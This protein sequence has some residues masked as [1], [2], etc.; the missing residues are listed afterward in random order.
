MN[1]TIQELWKV[2]ESAADAAAELLMKEH[3]EVKN[4][5]TAK[6]GVHEKTSPMDLVTRVD[7]EAQK[8][9]VNVITKIFPDHRFIAEEEGAA[10]IG[11]KDCPYVWIVDP[12]DGT[13]NFINGKPNFGTIVAVAKGDELLAGCM[14]MPALKQRFTGAKGL[15]ALVDDKPVKLRTTTRMAEATLTSNIT[16]RAKPDANG[17]LQTSLPR[18]AS[19]ENYGCAAEEM[20]DILQGWNDGAFFRGLRIWDLAAGLVILEEAGGKY[21]YELEEPANPRGG[22]LCAASITPIFDE[23]CDFVFEK[24]LA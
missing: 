20:G 23:L 9:I 24:R 5:G 18:C 10:D 1:P 21:R 17:V 4:H 19:V 11:K 13:K 8:C 2:A 14:V 22:V 15:G 12:L 6:L 3:L 7:C 16:R